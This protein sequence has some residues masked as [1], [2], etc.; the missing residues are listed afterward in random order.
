MMLVIDFLRRK[1]LEIIKGKR[2]KFSI[3]TDL[4]KEL[5]S[6]VICEL[7]RLT[8]TL[9][10]GIARGCTERRSD[11]RNYSSYWYAKISQLYSL[12]TIL[13]TKLL[14][15]GLIGTNLW[16]P[17]LFFPAYPDSHT[18]LLK[19]ITDTKCGAVTLIT[20]RA[21]W[22]FLFSSLLPGPQKKPRW[23]ELMHCAAR[24]FHKTS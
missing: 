1:R 24:A 17:A 15:H 5:E 14:F 2:I 20:N 9:L 13:P 3:E 10:S 6:N 18:N 8:Q 21:A 4:L 23:K 7:S 12:K 11:T 22:I 19:K 16:I